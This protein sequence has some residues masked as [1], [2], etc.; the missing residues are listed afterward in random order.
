MRLRG[1]PA[2]IAMLVYLAILVYSVY[3]TYRI[4]VT[5]HAWPF[6]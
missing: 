5:I 4:A 2:L 3:F 6:G 1:F